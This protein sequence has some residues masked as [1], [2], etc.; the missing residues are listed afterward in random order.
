MPDV[1][2]FMYFGHYVIVSYRDEWTRDFATGKRAKAFSG[3]EMF[4]RLKLDRMEA[5]AS[6]RDLAA[7]PGNRFEALVGTVKHSTVRYSSSRHH[8]TSGS[9]LTQELHSPLPGCISNFI[10]SYLTHERPTRPISKAKASGWE[11]GST[12]CSRGPD[13]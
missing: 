2:Y 12:F 10:G 6:L 9:P 7:S 5:P 1:T 4:A 11:T 13:R 8:S 3:F